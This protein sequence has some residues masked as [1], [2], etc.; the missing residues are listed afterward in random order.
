MRAARSRP[1]QAGVAGTSQSVHLAL[2]LESDL[3]DPLVPP[4]R[5]I[6]TSC[7]CPDRDHGSVCKHVAALAFVVADAID[8]DPSLLL[9]WRGCEPVAPP[10]SRAATVAL[11]HRPARCC[12][13]GPSSSGS[14]GR[15]SGSRARP[16]E[17]PSPPTGRSRA[18]HGCRPRHDR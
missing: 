17:A 5:R 1:A 7:T 11:P 16:A 10:A 12:T 15:A 4:T 6:R 2:F 8:S 13:P 18:P 9:H 14:G 3:H